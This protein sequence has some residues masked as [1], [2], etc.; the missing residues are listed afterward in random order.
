MLPNAIVGEQQEACDSH[1]TAFGQ[2]LSFKRCAEWLNS[3][4]KR[5]IVCYSDAR[6][7]QPDHSSAQSV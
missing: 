5:P 7:S 1:E 4:A 2:E 6:S 3:N